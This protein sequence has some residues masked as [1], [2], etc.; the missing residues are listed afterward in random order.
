MRFPV[1]VAS[2]LV[3]GASAALAKESREEKVRNDRA[4]VEAD[5][6]W[7]YND[8]AKGRAEAER[9]GKPMVVALRCIPCEECVKLDDE[10]VDKDTRVRPLLEKFVRVRIISTNG[11]DLST[12]QFDSDQSFTVFL[13]HAD[14]TIYGRYGTRSD[15]TE[16]ADDVS[17]EGLSKALEGALELHETP[18][19]ARAAVASALAK[20]KGPAPLFAT[21]ER[22]PSLKEKY[23][24]TLAEGDKTVPSCIHCHQIGEAERTFLLGKHGRLSEEVLLPYPHPK[25]VGLVLDPKERARVLRVDEGSPAAAAGFRAGDN[26]L[27]LA[28]QP[29]LSIADVQW[30]LHHTPPA[31]GTLEAIVGRGTLVKRISLRLGEGWRREDDLSWR[32]STWG[33]RRMALG[34]MKLNPLPAGD[35]AQAKLPKA[36]VGLRIAHVG[37]Y[38]PHDVAKRAGFKVGDVI[39]SFG[40]KTDLP[41][42]T[43]VLLYVLGKGRGGR[44]VSVKVLRGTE[45]LTLTLPPGAR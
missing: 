12:F 19:E 32:A 39:V 24:G 42:E 16:W 28:G 34:G 7:I 4:R 31:G 41:R 21:P 13:M 43:D 1:V 15:R 30:V 23:T 2:I 37:Q 29:L 40:G 5:G 18:P 27:E 36:A 45:E 22:F 35:P 26:L 20:K 8:L 33:L 38:A 9:T 6:F 3:L 17:I 14:G 44:D 11:L 25:A 10:L